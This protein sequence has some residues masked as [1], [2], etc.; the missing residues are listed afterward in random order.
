MRTI[1]TVFVLVLATARGAESGFWQQLTAEERARAGVDALTP[2]QRAALDELAVRYSTQ[3]PRAAAGAAEAAPAM[4]ARP[5]SPRAQPKVAT[6]EAN[7]PRIGLPALKPAGEEKV[8]SRIAGE[9]KGW[10]GA[11]IFKLENGQIWVQENPND[12]QWFKAEMNPPVEITRSMFGGWKLVVDGQKGSWVRVK[13][14][15]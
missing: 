5:A 9:F 4:A 11:T 7:D 13:R 15:Q 8:I 3:G 2:A 1:L 12:S 14:V 10:T 6:D